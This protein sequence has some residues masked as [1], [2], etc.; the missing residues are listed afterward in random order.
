MNENSKYMLNT[1][2]FIFC[3]GSA[4]DSRNSNALEVHEKNE[5]I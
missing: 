3:F 4:L 5:N 1:C 2:F